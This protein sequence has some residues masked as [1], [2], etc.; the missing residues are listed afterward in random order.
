MLGLLAGACAVNPVSQKREVVLVSV[1]DEI[2]MG[3]E[4][5]AEI[6]RDM[7]LY[8]SPRL[9]GY[10]DAIGARLEAFSPWTDVGYDFYVVDMVEPNAFALPGGHVYVSRGLLALMDDEDEL[11]GVIG[12]EMGHVAARHAVQR[13]TRSAPVG[14]LT[15]ITSGI[16]G[17]VSPTLGNVTAGIGGLTNS[18]L[19]SP[20]SRSQ[21][22]E[23]DEIGQKMAGQAGWD[24]AALS[25]FLDTLAKEEALLS[26]GKRPPSFLAS[27]PSTPSRVEKTAERARTLPRATTPPIAKGRGTFLN[28]LN[29][30][31]VGPRAVEGVFIEQ[32][33]LHPDMNFGLSFPEG[34]TTENTRNYVV[35]VAKDEK[36]GLVLMLHG[37]GTDPVQAGRD[38]LEQEAKMSPQEIKV[39]AAR[40]GGLPAARTTVDTREQKV[41]I[42]WIAQEGRIFRLMGTVKHQSPVYHDDNVREAINSYHVL[43]AAEREEIREDR[44][45][46]VKARKG[47]TLAEL[48]R[49]VDGQWE[50]PQA[51][52]ANGLEENQKLEAGQ[53]VKMPLSE[54]Y[55]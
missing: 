54:I 21:E 10:L 33:F 6:E 31:P 11:A 46:L 14:I 37:D 44:L 55:R 30:L 38:F 28:Y 8:E 40:I 49:R 5:A 13:M 48:I 26:D 45:R 16:V 23:A 9:G 18:L 53:T 7:G 24:P 19:V 17:I 32:R 50:L 2:A 1:E 43:S 39:T 12:H 35:G 34:W 22:D 27:H 42:A 52:V 41:R 25:V 36:A 51:A 47:E 29:G 4:A 3:D 15:G 20:Y